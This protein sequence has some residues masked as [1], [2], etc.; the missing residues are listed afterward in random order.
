MVCGKVFNSIKHHR[1]TNQTHHKI[2]LTPVGMAAFKKPKDRCCRRC[3]E[4]AT[5]LTV[6]GNAQSCSHYRKQYGGSRKKLK[7]EPT[8]RPRHGISGCVSKRIEIRI[9][10]KCL[11]SHVHC[12]IIC[13]SQ[14]IKTTQTSISR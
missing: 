13:N 1:N 4:R 11:L 3:G 6:G 9:M 14:E 5:L 7:I 10:M 8:R 2:P 12:S